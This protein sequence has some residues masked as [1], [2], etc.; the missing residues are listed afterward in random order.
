MR[1]SKGTAKGAKGVI[2]QPTN[3]LVGALLNTAGAT[4]ITPVTPTPPTTEP[5]STEQ[6]PTVLSVDNEAALAQLTAKCKQQEEQ[7]AK[8]EE[9]LRQM[10]EKLKQYEAAQYKMQ[11]HYEDKVQELIQQGAVLQEQLIKRN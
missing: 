9:E 11:E 6:Q 8:K 7:L 1:D 3:A 5:P 2:K 4:L 10:S